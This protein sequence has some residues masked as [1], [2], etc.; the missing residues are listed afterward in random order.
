MKGVQM[1]PIYAMIIRTIFSLFLLVTLILL[2][3]KIK[4][5]II[6]TTL[7]VVITITI[8]CVMMFFGNITKY[9]ANEK[10]YAII[11]N[12]IVILNNGKY[13]YTNSEFKT[14]A[15]MEELEYYHSFYDDD[16][17]RNFVVSIYKADDEITD[18]DSLIKFEKPKRAELIPNSVI[19]KM[20]ITEKKDDCQFAIFPK[21][22]MR[23]LSTP[24]GVY[25]TKIFVRCNGENYIISVTTKEKYTW[26]Q[27]FIL[28][29]HSNYDDITEI[30]AIIEADLTAI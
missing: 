16:D 15:E 26:I 17:G 14:Y 24:C 5:S 25:E 23:I 8:S 11:K 28:T 10:T 6:A 7:I 22:G 4:K 19:K 27:P 30:V 13:Q 21:L 3:K 18:D 20:M 2:F 29:G 12:C 1:Y 9:N